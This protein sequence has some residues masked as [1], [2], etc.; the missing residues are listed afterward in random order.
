MMAPLTWDPLLN[1]TDFN[2]VTYKIISL[3]IYALI[4]LKL[5]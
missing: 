1:I 4:Y 2:D 5:D 3:I